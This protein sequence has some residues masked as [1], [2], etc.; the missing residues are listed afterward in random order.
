MS[1]QS[2]IDFQE[3]LTPLTLVDAI[4]CDLSEAAQGAT[5]IRCAKIY[6]L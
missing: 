4:L 3:A 6:R 2:R 1:L 5:C